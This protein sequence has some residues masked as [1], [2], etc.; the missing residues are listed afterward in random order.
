M[1]IIVDHEHKLIYPVD[2]KTSSSPEWDFYK[3]FIKWRYDIQGR[4]YWRIIEDNIKRSEEFKDYKLMDYTFIVVNK[5]TLTPLVWTF[6][7]P[8]VYGTLK[9]GARGQIELEDPFKLGKELH[10]YLTN[11]VSVP[12]GILVDSSNDVSKWLNKLNL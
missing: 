4:L 12:I 6:P 10:Y 8:M 7:Q 5:E 3:S 1:L 2:L 9:F 11:N